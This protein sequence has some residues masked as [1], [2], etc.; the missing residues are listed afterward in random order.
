MSTFNVH[1]W[2]RKRRLG[3]IIDEEKK[4]VNEAPGVFA[5]IDEMIETL[6]THMSAED[7]LKE[8]MS[9]LQ[10]IS[11]G[12]KVLH[13][14][15]KNIMIDADLMESLKENSKKVTITEQFNKAEVLK[16]KEDLSNFLNTYGYYMA[17]LDKSKVFDAVGALERLLLE[18][19]VNESRKVKVTDAQKR[20]MLRVAQDLHNIVKT[21][22]D[23]DGTRLLAGR[24]QDRDALT[25]AARILEFLVALL[26][27]NQIK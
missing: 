20:Q 13:S 26:D 19:G 10:V 22:H 27:R 12:T 2:N 16:M 21:H 24:M 8:L 15:L 4:K 11:G 23:V 1:E 6:A 18:K 17:P 7:V 3:E 9:E 5:E 14:A 25:R